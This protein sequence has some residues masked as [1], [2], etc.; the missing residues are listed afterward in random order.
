MLRGKNNFIFY[1]F[2]FNLNY[3]G[4]NLVLISFLDNHLFT[5]HAGFDK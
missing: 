2:S 1:K 3:I 5:R 4:E